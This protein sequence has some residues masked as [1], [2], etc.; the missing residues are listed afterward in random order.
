[1]ASA[2]LGNLRLLRDSMRD[3]DWTID[4]FTFTYK[5]ASYF[6]VVELYKPGEKVPEY[7][8]CK[9]TFMD[10]ADLDRVLAA[11]ANT[12]RVMANAKTLREYFGIEWKEN[13]GE[14]LQQF[15]EQ[16]NEFVPVVF[17][18]KSDLRAKE[19]MAQCLRRGDPEAYCFKVKRNPL[20]KDGMPGQR[21]P[22]N[23]SKARL[24]RPSL[25]GV[26]R[27][28]RSVSF[29]FSDDPAKERSDKEIL[30]EFYQG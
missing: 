16:L 14:M 20:R 30:D 18:E 3:S 4:V 28:D 5:Q 26:F 17:E 15:S 25:Y 12:K 21:S 6:V 2:P 19:V 10:K 29:Y 24:L 9:L 23:D 1:M 22:F 7:A 8:L 11:P 27:N 13:I